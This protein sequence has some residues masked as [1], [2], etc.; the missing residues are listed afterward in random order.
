MGAEHNEKIGNFIAIAVIFFFYLMIAFLTPLT[1]DDWVWGSDVGISRLNSWF[2]NYNGRYF[3]NILVLIFTRN[4]FIKSIIMA[5]INTGMIFFITKI[6]WKKNSYIN[7]LIIWILTMIIPLSIFSQTYAWASG[8]VN[9][10]MAAFFTLLAIYLF[11]NL[12]NSDWQGDVDESKVTLIVVFLV[13]FFA[14]LFAEHVTVYNVILSMFFLIMTVIRKD[15]K[16][17]A[18]SFMLGTIGGAIMMFTNQSYISIMQGKDTYRS[19]DNT[20]FIERV[21]KI[22]T[23]YM[24]EQLIQNNYFINLTISLL[25]VIVVYRIKGWN[26]LKKIFSVFLLTY[27]L[28][29]LI[30]KNI[31]KISFVS[32]SALFKY[33]APF[34]A[35]AYILVI[36]FSFLLMI[37]KNKFSLIFYICS[38]AMVAAPLFFVT[39]L[40][41][42]CFFSS[43][44]FLVL[45]GGTLFKNVL[46]ENISI[47]VKQVT[48]LVATGFA[49]IFLMVFVMINRNYNFR[50]EYV[51]S[52]ILNGKKEVKMWSIPND[53]FL[54]ESTPNPN[55]YMEK[56]FRKYYN[57][58]EE[59]KF[60]W[61][62]TK[63]II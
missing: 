40:S 1:C 15:K 54:W 58:P 63:D 25:I 35:F 57:I 18:V 2:D 56:N 42:R 51:N 33:S 36:G 7:Y 37:E 53:Q 48:S 41:P 4:L 20:G 43:Y 32:N 49:C 24:S 14:Q 6:I 11:R 27:P 13:G 44:L 34:F 17:K 62:E 22:F 3:G 16:N 26:K 46:P 19:I 8:F 5:I 47:P 39:P 23:S 10:N 9:Y 55:G 45:I 30:G 59:V 28:Y 21:L 31:M 50:T 29:Y 60:I 38:F 61:V 52:M 12:V